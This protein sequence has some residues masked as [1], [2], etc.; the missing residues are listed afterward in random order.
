[1]LMVMFRIFITYR[2]LR[3]F[4]VIG[5]LIMLPGV[6]LGLRYLWLMANGLGSGNTQSLILAAVFL[7]AGFFVILS[8]FLADLISVN[9][10]L[11]EEVRTRTILLEY[12]LLG[13]SCGPPFGKPAPDRKKP[14]MPV[15]HVNLADV[16]E[17]QL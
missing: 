2:P 5:T 9:R 16:T 1:M 10:K 13:E 11:L 14:P 7:L 8:G 4:F 6:A 15:D 17:S 3:F 12:H